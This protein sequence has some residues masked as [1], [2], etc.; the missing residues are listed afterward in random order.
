MKKAAKALTLALI[1]LG[2]VG[3]DE[4]PTP[5]SAAPT[6]ERL[7]AARNAQ[8]GNK[9][10]NGGGVMPVAD[11]PPPPGVRTGAPDVGQKYKGP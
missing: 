2:L 10:K 7:E 8:G 3:C 9:A 6:G 5:V 4:A 1:G 11:P